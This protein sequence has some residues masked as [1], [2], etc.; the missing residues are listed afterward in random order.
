MPAGSASPQRGSVRIFS[1]VVVTRVEESE[2]L[3]DDDYFRNHYTSNYGD[4]GA[5]YDDYAPAYSYGAQMAGSGRYAG[6][7]WDEVES[8][9]RSEWDSRDGSGGQS[10]WERMK[11]AVRHGWERIRVHARD[12]RSH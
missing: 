3:P 12:G 1:H 9:L 7:Q 11:A 4:C 5:S 10:T 6:R 2:G 8:D